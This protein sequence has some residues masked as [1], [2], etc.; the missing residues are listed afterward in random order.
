MVHLVDLWLPILLSAVAVFVISSVIHM[1]LQI[2][3]GDYR[4]MPGE[5]VV[6]ATLRAQGVGA[7]QYMFPCA[8]SMKEMSSPEM[9]A[10]FKQ[11][12]V[13]MVVVRS[14]GMALGQSLLQ[15]FLYTILIGV[16]VAYVAGLALPHGA[17]FKAVFRLASAAAVLGYAFSN[18]SDSIWKGVAWSTTFRFL[19]DGV[20]YGVATGAAFAWLWP[21]AA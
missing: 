16:F 14:G 17:G 21:A 3:K 8:A 5:D 19:F 4:K 6:L 2:H 11:G 7:G 18:V 20:V 15:W 13:G 10:K 9:L 12:P 1:A